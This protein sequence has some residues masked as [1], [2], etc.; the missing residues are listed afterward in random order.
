M[1]EL[2]SK[3]LCK[4]IS[5]AL[6]RRLDIFLDTKVRSYVNEQVEGMV[7]ICQEHATQ[8][9]NDTAHD[10]RNKMTEIIAEQVEV[11]VKSAVRETSV[12]VVS[13][14]ITQ[15]FEQSV[16]DEIAK[17]EQRLRREIPDAVYEKLV[18]E[19][20]DVAGMMKRCGS[21]PR[22]LE[23]SGLALTGDLN[24][25]QSTE[26]VQ[27]VK[28]YVQSPLAAAIL[29]LSAKE[30]SKQMA[31]HVAGIEVDKMDRLEERVKYLENSQHYH[32]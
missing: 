14:G 23:L 30:F 19:L 27:G 9:V 12:P 22:L 1:K 31:Q 16:A 28:N 25:A 5:P 24:R 4:L 17:L 26:L 8:T 21:S 11:V 20:K 29:M 15:D 6:N 18:M 13:G 7:E 2:L 32:D 10:L 3:M